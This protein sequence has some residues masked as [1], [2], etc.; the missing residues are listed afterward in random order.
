MESEKEVSDEPVDEDW[1]TRFFSYAGEIS[2]EEMQTLWAQILAGEVKRPKSFSLRTLQVLRNLTKDE[3]RV[4]TT[5]SNYVIK[6]DDKT[7]V[8][9]GNYMDSMRSSLH[10]FEIGFDDISLLREIGLVQYGESINLQIVSTTKSI[11][12]TF[13]QIGDLILEAELKPAKPT[14]NL[15]IILYTSIGKELLNLIKPVRKF[16]YVQK[17]AKVLWEKGANVRWGE[18]E[19]VKEDGEIVHTPL[20][21]FPSFQIKF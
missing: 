5:V 7:Y 4:F 14:I 3:A 15:P 21:E 19:E 13:F 1:I 10:D 6:T 18:I 9:I 8:Y 12:T 17:L 20:K 16:E 11:T 2:T